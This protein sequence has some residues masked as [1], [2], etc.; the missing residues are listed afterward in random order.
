MKLHKSQ[1]G[2]AHLVIILV[3]VALAAVSFAGWKVF[4]NKNSEKAKIEGQSSSQNVTE[5]AIDVDLKAKL[6]VKLLAARVEE[7]ASNHNGKYPVSLTE[8]SDLDPSIDLS[9][10][11]Y[12]LTSSRKYTI[13]VKLSDGSNQTYSN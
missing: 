1:S 13:S 8:L 9:K 12:T 5:E 11:T 6:N 7:Y 2:I 4:K 10:F 3:I